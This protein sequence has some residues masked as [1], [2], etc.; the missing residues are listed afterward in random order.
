MM[1]EQ[2][3][4]QKDIADSIFIRFYTDDDIRLEHTQKAL[5][6]IIPCFAEVS[7]R[8]GLEISLS[9]TEVLRQRAPEDDPTTPNI[10]IKETNL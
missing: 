8:L 2:A 10:S 7:K 1:L 3:A 6:H 9:K 4:P 5:Q